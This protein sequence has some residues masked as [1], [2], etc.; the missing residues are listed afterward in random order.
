[1]RLFIAIPLSEKMKQSVAD[2]QG[3]FQFRGV[4][5]NYTPEENLHVTLAFIGEYGDP[6][7][8]LDALE[9]ISFTPFKI[10]MGGVGCFDDLW[11]VGLEENEALQNLAMKV[12][13]TLSDAGIPFDRKRF[14]AHV[15]ILR[16]AVFTRGREINVW[17]DPT[18]MEVN[19]ISLM[20]STRGKHGMIY[21]EIGRVEG[22]R[23]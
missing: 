1:M 21:T 3:A 6:N 7:A 23:K 5:G 9:E 19:H 18:E 22:E 13:R 2:A 12:R 4:R 20:C 11:W 16:Q 14:K 10:K 17:V 8:V 15:T